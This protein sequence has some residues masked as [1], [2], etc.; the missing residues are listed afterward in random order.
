MSLSDFGFGETAIKE[1]ACD[2]VKETAAV[3]SQCNDYTQTVLIVGLIVG[4][5]V[6]AIG[7]YAGIRY[8]GSKK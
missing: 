1:V 6:G 7:M 3:I 8:H 4:M 5:I 2:C